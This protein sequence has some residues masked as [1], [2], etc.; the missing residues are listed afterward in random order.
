[1]DISWTYHGHM[2]HRS[3]QVV[4]SSWLLHDVHAGICWLPRF[5]VTSKYWS[6]GASERLENISRG[7]GTAYFQ[8]FSQITGLLCEEMLGV[9]H[10]YAGSDMK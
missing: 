8:D 3:A 9:N 4:D 5:P 1:M 2:T 7:Y 6:L 10:C